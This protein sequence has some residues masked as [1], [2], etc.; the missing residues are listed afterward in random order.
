MPTETQPGSV[1][2]RLRARFGR[3]RCPIGPAPA[4][5]GR[6]EPGADAAG[7]SLEAGS[8]LTPEVDLGPL[9][10][11]LADP[12]VSDICVNGLQVWV[13]RGFGM[14]L[15]AVRFADVGTVREL[16]VRLAE[17]CGRRLDDAQP[18]VDAPLPTGLRLHAVLP[19]LAPAGPLISLR[20]SRR[21]QLGLS[22]LRLCG[23]F[24]EAAEGLLAGIVRA[25]LS[26]L[27]T[28]G[29]G[30]GKTTLL[31]AL[32]A[33]VD[34]VERVVAVEDVAELRP[35]LP[36]FVRL[37]ARPPNAEGAGG[38]DL[39]TLVREALRMRPDRLVVGECRGAEVIHLLAALNSGQQGG[40][41]TLHANHPADVPARL[42]ALAL[43]AGLT[44]GGLHAQLR[45]GVAACLH[46]VRLRG[47]RVLA[48]ICLATAEPGGLV[49]FV[50]AW[51]RSQTGE[52][53]PGPA[54]SRLTELLD[55]TR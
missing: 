24:T 6:A 17:G 52:L 35:E 5:A 11:L 1:R 51:T 27:V 32:L 26:F 55:A 47:G 16:A 3:A 18:F 20:T 49:S 34:P 9:T 25:R 10:P 43:A 38:V 41:S 14:Q 36:H 40:C 37:V 46:V 54:C 31:A 15:A 39:G 7:R 45:S 23:T 53:T 19:P 22:G 21:R 28:G 8:Q 48:A 50:P 13:D 4:A 44:R 2:T 33:A 30:S 12:A 42:E 29:P